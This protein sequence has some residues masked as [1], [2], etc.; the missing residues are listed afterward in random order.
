[1]LWDLK[2]TLGKNF[3]FLQKIKGKD[4][5]SNSAVESGKQPCVVITAWG[6]GW[7]GGAG[8][9]YVVFMPGLVPEKHFPFGQISAAKSW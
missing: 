7:E 5:H 9:F 6:G 1:M 2:E 4:T 3:C 8:C